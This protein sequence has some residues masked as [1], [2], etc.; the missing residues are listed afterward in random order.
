VALYVADALYTILTHVTLPQL[1]VCIVRKQTHNCL[2]VC[3]I[4]VCCCIP[5]VP[6]ILFTPICPHSLSFRPLMFPDYVQLCVQVGV[7]RLQLA[8]A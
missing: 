5:Q 3:C 4:A 8:C 7:L 6:C 2:Q 1:T